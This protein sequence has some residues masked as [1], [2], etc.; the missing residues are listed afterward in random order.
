M[1]PAAFCLSGDRQLPPPRYRNPI[2][3]PRLCSPQSLLELGERLLD[4]VAIG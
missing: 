4:R 1:K 3:H 2:E